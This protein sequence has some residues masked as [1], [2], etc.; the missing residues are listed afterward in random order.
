MKNLYKT[1][2]L[3]FILVIGCSNS[4]NNINNDN[5]AKGTIQL[6]GV[7]TSEVGT[8][9]V[10]GD[11]AEGRSDLTGNEDSIII[12]EKGT[13]ISKT[14]APFPPGDPR[15]IEIFEGNDPNNGFVIVVGADSISMS[16]VVN[17]TPFRYACVSGFNTFI[18]CDSVDLNLNENKIVFNNSTVENTE[19][20]AI[21][22]LNGTLTW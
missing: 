6:S 10:V 18:D 9:L 12:V 2:F 3:F 15:N 20:G 21:L 1:H 22:T 7:D 4:D 14:P 17:G 11:I 8:A 16:I 19:T 5:D 13:T